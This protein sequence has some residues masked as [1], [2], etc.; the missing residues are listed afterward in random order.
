VAVGEENG[1]DLRIATL[2]VVEVEQAALGQAIAQLVGPR[3]HDAYPSSTTL[4]VGKEHKIGALQLVQLGLA[5]NAPRGGD[6]ILHGE[7]RQP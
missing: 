7:K 1:R 3:E 4:A 2:Q 5:A 6:A